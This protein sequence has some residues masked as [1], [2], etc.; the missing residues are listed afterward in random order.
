MAPPLVKIQLL[1]F[2]RWNKNRSYTEKIKYPL[3][4]NFMQPMLISCANYFE[5]S[6]GWYKK[7]VKYINLKEL[8]WASLNPI[9][10]S[11][12]VWSSFQVDI[13]IYLRKLSQS[14]ARTLSSH[15]T[16]WFTIIHELKFGKVLFINIGV[17]RRMMTENTKNINKFLM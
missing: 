8:A 14:G 2:I 11:G 17:F 9:S 16:I 3:Y 7:S 4:V 10:T 6:G 12:P 1:V 15:I 5:L 13:E